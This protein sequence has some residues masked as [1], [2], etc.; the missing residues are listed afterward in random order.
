VRLLVV[1]DKD[2]FRRQL[3]AGLEPE[4][5][6]VAE[7]SSGEAALE[8]LPRF[9]PE[10]VL[11]D[12]K[13]PG[14]SGIEAT[15]RLLR[16]APQTAVIMLSL[17]DGDEMVEMAEAAGVSAYLVKDARLDQ[18]LSAIRAAARERSRRQAGRD[19][20]GGGMD[21]ARIA[22]RTGYGE[23]M[24]RLRAENRRLHRRI[25]ALQA[26]KAE[27]KAFA[28]VA[29]H[30]LLAP[31]VLAEAYATTVTDRLDEDLHADARRDLEALRRAASRTRLL[32]EA[33]LHDAS[34]HD[35]PL[36]RRA[37]DLNVLVRECRTLLAPEIRARGADV[38]VADLP[39]AYGDETLISAV[40]T[41]LLL[42]ALR[43]GPRDAGTIRVDAV[44]EDGSCRCS[45]QSAGLTIPVADRER[46]FERYHRGRGERRAPGAGL[47]LTICR[48]I[49]ERH[50]GQIGVTAVDA[51][52]NSFY[53]TLP[54][55]SARTRREARPRRWHAPSA[56]AGV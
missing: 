5:F 54:A 39:R 3:R 52:V 12:A 18:I 17:F 37:I 16:S 35:R 47:G 4:G 1:D 15:R 38:Q 42:N 9:R 28:A 44:L 11:M 30:E 34:S 49:V 26:E 25:A 50:G 31:L 55:R 36:R 33:L 45:V 27:V 10:V 6:E 56:P 20:D 24:D 23:P 21:N 14:M 48:R 51:G 29:A 43:Y 22:D 13:M 32:V 2:V 19:L 53:F 8:C 41:N 7:A 46:I 40:F